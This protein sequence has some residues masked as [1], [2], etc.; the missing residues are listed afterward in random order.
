MN[1]RKYLILIE[2]AE[3][4]KYGAYVPDLPGCAVCGY[5]TPDEATESIRIAI[6]MHLQGML[7]DGDEIPAPVTQSRY[8]EANVA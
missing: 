7:K 6:D 1:N 8:V 4:G 3:D 5:P 2:I